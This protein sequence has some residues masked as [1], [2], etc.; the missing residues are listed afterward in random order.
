M[1]FAASGLD[2]DYE[3]LARLLL[4]AEGVASSS[5]EGV[6]APV[7]DVVLAEEMLPSDSAAA[8]VAAN[9]AALSAA[10]AEA[11]TGQLSVD[12]LCDWH[13][14]LMAGSPTPGRYVGV[15]RTEQG[16]IGGTDPTNAA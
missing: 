4:R 5:I 13:R 1:G 16:W 3:P 8:W 6:R 10:V 15:I 7:A 11:P 14:T 12:I 9:L 2:A